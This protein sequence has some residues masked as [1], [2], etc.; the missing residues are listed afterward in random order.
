MTFD[1]F[2]AIFNNANRPGGGDGVFDLDSGIF[3]CFTSGYYTISFSA[4]GRV[5]PNYGPQRLYLYKNS[6]KLSESTWVS[7]IIDGAVNNN[8]G[9]IGSRIMV[10]SPLTMLNAKC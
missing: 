10:S 7:Y 5:G 1:S 9:F 8:I 6:A 4:Y 2:L 3:T